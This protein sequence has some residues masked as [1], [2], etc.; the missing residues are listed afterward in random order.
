[1]SFM[2]FPVSEKDDLSVSRAIQSTLDPTF[3]SEHQVL[4]PPPVTFF[5]YTVLPRP[6]L[7]IHYFLYIGKY[8]LI[9]P[10]FKK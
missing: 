5:I 2:V 9:S 7:C 3:L 4:D 1:M 8:T 6:F 10:D